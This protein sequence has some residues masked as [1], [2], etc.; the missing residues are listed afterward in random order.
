M[1]TYELFTDILHMESE[2]E[3]VS[4]LKEKGIWENPE[5]WKPYGDMANNIG[6][7][8]NQQTN[9]FAAFAEKVV[10]S[11]DA[12]FMREC[13]REGID[14]ESKDAPASMKL[15]KEKYKNNITRDDIQI[16]A[17]G[18]EKTSINVVIADYGEGQS[19]HDFEKTLLSLNKT[20]KLK[21]PFV[22]GKFN[23]GSTGVIPFCGKHN[24]QLL[25][26][27]KDPKIETSDSLS[28]Y[29]TF[30]ITRKNSFDVTTKSSV[31]ECLKIDGRMPLI[32]KEVLN[33]LP[34]KNTAGATYTEPMTWGTYI[35][36][37]NYKSKHT[38]IIKGRFTFKL[39]QILPGMPLDAF[40]SDR[41]DLFDTASNKLTTTLKGNL[42]RIMADDRLE[43]GFPL[44]NILNIH[45]EQIK[46]EIF[47]IKNLKNNN[48]FSA[49]KE[50]EGIAYIVNGQVH[51]YTNQRVFKRKGIDLDYIYR[52]LLIYVDITDIDKALREEL[53]MSNR[54]SLRDSVF[55][56]ELEDLVIDE[57]KNCKQLYLENERVRKEKLRNKTNDSS[58]I[59]NSLKKVLKTNPTIA[60]LFDMGLQLPNVTKVE[61]SEKEKGDFIG[62]D[63]PTFFELTKEFSIIMPKEVPIN[64]KFR[65][66][67]KTDVKDNFFNRDIDTGIF[68]LTNQEEKKFN[69]SL[70]LRNGLCTITGTL[71]ESI[72]V[73]EILIFDS[74][75]KAKDKEFNSQFYIRAIDKE[76]IKSNTSKNKKKKDNPKLNLPHIEEVYKNDWDEWE[77]DETSV[78]KINGNDYILNMDNVYLK[79]NIKKDVNKKDQYNE[80]YK[81]MYLMYGIALEHKNSEIEDEEEKIDIESTTS[82]LAPVIFETSYII[83]E[84]RK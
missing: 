60:A 76:D 28:N 59:L 4:L 16:Y 24:I 33:I 27:K 47:L 25:V 80:E 71:P 53:V 81:A 26:S 66:H 20:N 21:I 79:K 39:S 69:Y 18:N 70:S 42:A 44:N 38:S 82:A 5:Y 61:T 29:W 68:T 49:F 15:A 37:Y 3:V 12:L 72:K 23:M 31:I 22:Q 32:K 48:D 78:L 58:H 14:P 35:K 64:K 67:F 36:L 6:T 57:I 41:R 63:E 65:I 13:K 51:G 54:E 56:Q 7:I 74:V 10:N 17:T 43:K 46:V 45:N 52:N 8:T 11:I 75:V 40:V 19:P 2:E 1:N 30:T 9:A 83:E 50:E 62:V 73:D 77:F 34:D 55:K 84:L